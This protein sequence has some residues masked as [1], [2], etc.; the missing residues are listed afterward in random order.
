MPA[1]GAQRAEQRR[2]RRLVVEVERLGI[3]L[4]RELDDGSALEGVRRVGD[5]LAD[6]AILEVTVGLRACGLGG[7]AP[8]IREGRAGRR[9]LALGQG[10]ERRSAAGHLD[11]DPR[12][13]KF[14]LAVEKFDRDPRQADVAAGRQIALLQHAIARVVGLIWAD[15]LL[16]EHFFDAGGAQRGHAI[17]DAVAGHAHH[18]GAGVEA[19]SAEAADERS[20]RGLLVDVHGLGVIG[21]AER[22]DLRLGQRARAER[23]ALTGLQV[24]VVDQALFSHASIL[25]ESWGQIVIEK[26]NPVHNRRSGWRPCGRTLLKRRGRARRSRG[27]AASD[28]AP[29]SAASGFGRAPR[30][31]RLACGAGRCPACGCRSRQACD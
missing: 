10:L 14:V 25:R 21:P 17:E 13:G 2:L 23:D 12:G 4:A 19:R 7:S 18:D 28:R 20:F 15:G 16:P 31:R 26:P 3:E 9:V 24:L 1:G 11:R 5:G 22:D 30:R 29:R 6:L 8:D 27:T